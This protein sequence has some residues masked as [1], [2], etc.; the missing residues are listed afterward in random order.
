MSDLPDLEVLRVHP[1]RR[2]EAGAFVDPEYILTGVFGGR[3]AYRIEDRRYLVVGG[4][5]VLMRPH[6]AHLLVPEG[7]A[8]D[9]LVVHLRVGA[10]GAWIGDCPEVARL[11]GAR[12]KRVSR[13]LREIAREW[14]RGEAG[15]AGLCAGLSVAVLRELARAGTDRVAASIER[16]G[17]WPTVERAW[18]AMHRRYAE[19]I[20]VAEIAREVE[21]SPAHLS[22]LFAH[23]AGRGPA[24]VLLDLRIE[25]AQELLH[26]GGL[27]CAEVAARCGFA[28]V[29][30]FSRSFK[31][32][33]GVSPT[34]WLERLRRSVA[35]GDA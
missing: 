15:H 19:P 33:V 3:C 2:D 29:P 18:A 7:G 20:G 13:W 11:G 22:R 5:L 12:W 27:G 34:R 14:D 8:V 17:G 24:R 26:R 28:S 16:G 30:A 10:G 35:L 25:R 4:D 23:H 1:D 31:Q 21:V 32:R 9:H 6:L